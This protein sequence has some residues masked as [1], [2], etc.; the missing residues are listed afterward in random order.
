MQTY[1][2]DIPSHKAPEQTLCVPS[3]AT[4]MLKMGPEIVRLRG[5]EGCSNLHG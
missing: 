3:V 5:F 4:S 1:A 2:V